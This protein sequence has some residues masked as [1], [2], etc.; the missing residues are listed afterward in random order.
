MGR[1]CGVVSGEIWREGTAASI[2][3]YSG[4][5]SKLAFLYSAIKLSVM[6][7]PNYNHPPTPASTSKK[8]VISSCA[9]VNICLLEYSS[10]LGLRATVLMVWRENGIPYIEE[11]SL[12]CRIQPAVCNKLWNVCLADAVDTGNMSWSTVVRLWPDGAGESVQ[13]HNLLPSFTSALRSWFQE[14]PPEPSLLQTG[15]SSYSWLKGES[16]VTTPSTNS[17]VR[18]W[19]RALCF[20][21]VKWH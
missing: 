19:G 8:K 21:H 14:K 20:I 10:I 11:C 1:R 15:F 3:A 12:L 7:S 17:A 4:V 13:W 6:V 16:T 5:L 2:C 18:L 9:L